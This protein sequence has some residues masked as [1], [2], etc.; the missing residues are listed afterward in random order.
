LNLQIFGEYNYRCKQVFDFLNDLI[1]LIEY[2][3]NRN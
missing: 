3:T 1:E 2:N